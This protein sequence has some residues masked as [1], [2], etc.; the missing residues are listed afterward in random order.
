MENIQS[1]SVDRHRK[2]L[3][4][5]VQKVSSEKIIFIAQSWGTLLAINYLQHN[6]DRIEKLILTGPGP[7]LPINHQVKNAISP[8]SLKLRSPKYSNQEGNRKAYHLRSKLVMKWA[9]AFGTKLGSDAEMDDFFTYLNQELSKSTNCDIEASKKYL[10]GGGYYAHIMTVRSFT[11]A[12][13]QRAKLKDIDIP[14][15]IMRGQ[16]DNQK[17]GYTQEYLSIF[18]NITLEI[19]E[20]AG[21]DLLNGNR[22]RYFELIDDF[23]KS[24]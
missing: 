5:I 14:I 20:G 17:W 24:S 23:I 10:G 11:E 21:H 9:H 3:E 18:S 2:D 16:C 22:L 1:Y 7:I 13:D 4:A 15:L 12:K 6:P 8:D 19:I